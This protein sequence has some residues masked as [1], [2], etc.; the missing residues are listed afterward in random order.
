V[1][2]ASVLS[3]LAESRRLSE[4]RAEGPRDCATLAND[5]PDLGDAGAV[6]LVEA[7]GAVEG[8]PGPL[9]EADRSA[10]GV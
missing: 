3:V 1:A 2:A 10:V 6:V 7:A 8:E 9:V 5:Q 4:S